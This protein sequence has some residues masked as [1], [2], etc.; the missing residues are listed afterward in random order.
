MS[1]VPLY[2]QMR[3]MRR[4]AIKRVGDF[5]LKPGTGFGHDCL[6]FGIDCLIIR[7]GLSYIWP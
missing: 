7:P 3:G 5:H 2:S 4:Q 1:E 6:I